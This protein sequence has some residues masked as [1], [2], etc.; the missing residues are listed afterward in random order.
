MISFQ[1]TGT[2][3]GTTIKAVEKADVE[4]TFVEIENIL[5]TRIGF[6]Y[7]LPFDILWSPE[8]TWILSAQL[9]TNWFKILQHIQ[10]T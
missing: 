7:K 5:T 8:C 4:P 10:N 1:K 3:E 2:I 6:L 9:N